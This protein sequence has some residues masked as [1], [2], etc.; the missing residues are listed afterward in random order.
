[1]RLPLWFIFIAAMLSHVNLAIIKP[2]N[3]NCEGAGYTPYSQTSLEFLQAEYHRKF[4]APPEQMP[5]DFKL[6][7]M[8]KMADIKRDS[9]IKCGTRTRNV[10]AD[11]DITAAGVDKKAF[12]W[13]VA[14]RGSKYFCAGVLLEKNYVL[15]PSRCVDS[16]TKVMFGHTNIKNSTGMLQVK[17]ESSFLQ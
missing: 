9:K 2:W 11:N 1:M 5:N 6:S 12:P 4:G 7:D 17:H 8:S 13:I 14:V 3:D 16:T 10:S 15:S